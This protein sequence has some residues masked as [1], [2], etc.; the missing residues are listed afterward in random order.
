[1]LSSQFNKAMGLGLTLDG[2]FKKVNAVSAFYRIYNGE[3]AKVRE[4][5]KKP[6]V[7]SLYSI[8]A[9]EFN[10]KHVK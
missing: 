1:M 10:N 5:V 8:K 4:W 2:H 6:Y 7:N 3:C 9:I